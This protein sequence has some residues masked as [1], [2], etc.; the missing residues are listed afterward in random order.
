MSNG[1]VSRMNRIA[2]RVYPKT[3]LSHRKPAR[4]CRQTSGGGDRKKPAETSGPDPTDRVRS[5]RHTPN[6]TSPTL[7]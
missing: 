7:P 3:R 1:Q 6:E 2:P 5:R 4:T